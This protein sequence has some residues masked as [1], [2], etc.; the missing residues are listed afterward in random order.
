MMSPRCTSVYGSRCFDA[1]V[2][3][4]VCQLIHQQVVAHQQRVFHGAGGDDKRLQQIGGS[5]QQQ[6][7]RDAPFGD[8]AA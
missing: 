7:D 6:D 4:R 3:R 5:E 8:E 1:A 2:R